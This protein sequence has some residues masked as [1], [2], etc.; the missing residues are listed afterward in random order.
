MRFSD[1]VH[2]EYGPQ[3]KLHVIRKPGMR[4]CHSCIQENPEPVEKDKKCCHCWAAIDHDFKSDINFYEVA[5]NTNRKM[6]Q[7]CYIDQILE[8]IV[9]PWIEAK[10][11]FVLEKDGDSGHK[12][13]K[14]NI[15]RTWKARAWPGILLQLSQLSRSSAY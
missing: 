2:F 14:S 4:C 11:V 15:V 6:S 7:Q 5:G 13:G 3:E 9:K 10:Q 1:E 12:P 8:P